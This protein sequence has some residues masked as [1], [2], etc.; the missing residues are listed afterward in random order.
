MHLCFKPALMN[1]ILSATIL[2]FAV[3]LHA[4]ENIPSMRIVYADID[5]IYNNLP[6]AKQIDAELKSLQVQ[7]ENQ[8]KKKYEDFK[9]Q[10]DVYVIREK[11]MT[12]LEQ[13]NAQKE[14]QTMQTNLEKLEEDS[15]M[16]FQQKQVELMKP[17]TTSIQQAI[18]DVAREHQ[19][20]FIV[21]AGTAK[22]D[23]IL[24]ADEA[25]NV[26]KLILE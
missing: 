13:Q 26:S 16:K 7:L 11:S 18:A 6:A 1:A 22:Q 4:Q 12:P 3:A 5:F 8:L 2:F 20:A 17:V 10:Y 25:H 24:H 23:V 15:K 21:N 14:L 9:R 19:Y